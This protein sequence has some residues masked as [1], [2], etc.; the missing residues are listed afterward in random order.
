MTLFELRLV[1]SIREGIIMES[2]K[3]INKIGR[4]K[5]CMATLKF[6]LTLVT[7]LFPSIHAMME[8]IGG[9]NCFFIRIR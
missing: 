1:G 6:M 9:K 8:R 4:E 5:D 7:C 3:G 2:G